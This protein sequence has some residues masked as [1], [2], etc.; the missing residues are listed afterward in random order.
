MSGRLGMEATR[1]AHAKLVQFYNHIA[2]V[3]SAH[4]WP[5]RGA[6]ARVA[7]AGQVLRLQ[8]MPSS[9]NAGVAARI[10]R[11]QGL[12][13]LHPNSS[14]GTR[15]AVGS[16]FVE[17]HFLRD[18]LF[19]VVTV[20]TGVLAS[21]GTDELREGWSVP[22]PGLEYRQALWDYATAMRDEFTNEAQTFGGNTE[23]FRQR[24]EHSVDAASMYSRFLEREFPQGRPQQEQQSSSQSGARRSR[25]GAASQ[26][27]AGGP[28]RTWSFSGPSANA[29]ADPSG[30]EQ[31]D[32]AGAS[33]AHPDA[34][35]P[36]P[37]QSQRGRA[38]TRDSGAGG[39][40]N[41]NSGHR[42]SS[43]SSSSSNSNS[44][45]SSSGGGGRHSSNSNSSSS[46]SSGDGHSGGSGNNSTGG[47][48]GSHSTRGSSSSN[49]NGGSGSRSGHGSGR[50]RGRGRGGSGRGSGLGRGRGSGSGRGRGRGRG[51]ARGA[52]SDRASA[53]RTMKPAVVPLLMQALLHLP[54]IRPT[55]SRSVALQREQFSIHSDA[56]WCALVGA[57]KT[58]VAQHE[59]SQEG[60]SAAAGI[61]RRL[62]A[63]MQGLRLKLWQQFSP[64]NRPTQPNGDGAHYTLDGNAANSATYLAFSLTEAEQVSFREA[65]QPNLN[66]ELIRLAVHNSG[67]ARSSGSS[68]ARRGMGAG[69]AGREGAPPGPVD[70]ATHM[71]RLHEHVRRFDPAMPRPVTDSSQVERLEGRACIDRYDVETCAV[72]QMPQI[73]H[74]PADRQ[75]RARWA[76]AWATVIGWVREAQSVGDAA[77]LDRSLKWYLIL[78]AVIFRRS[79]KG[80]SKGKHPI[81][82]RLILFLGGNYKGLLDWY[83]KDRERARACGSSDSQHSASNQVDVAL[84]KLKKGW[85]S[86][87]M[88]SLAST[89]GLA[90]MSNPEVLADLRSRFPKRKVT[91]TLPLPEEYGSFNKVS[92]N[93]REHFRTLDDGRAT[94]LTGMRNEYLSALSAR[95]EDPVANEAIPK[96]EW[97]GEQLL[98]GTLPPWFHLTIASVILVPLAKPGARDQA[99]PVSVGDAFRCAVWSAAVKQ[100]K[101][102][103]E[104]VCWPYQT[105]C[106]TKGAAA[107]QSV[108]VK[109]L[110]KQ[111]PDWAVITTD[112]KNCHSELPRARMADAL[113]TVPGARDLIPGVIADMSAAQRVYTRDETG[114][115]SPM[116]DRNGNE[117]RLEEG[118]QQGWPPSAALCGLLL[119]P[120]TKA[121]DEVLRSS[122]GMCR[123]YQDDHYALG[124]VQLAVQAV[125]VL[126]GKDDGESGLKGDLGLD[127][128]K[129]KNTGFSHDPD[130]RKV[131][132]ERHGVPLM[133]VR[134]DGSRVMVDSM[135]GSESVGTGVVTMGV[136]I[137]EEAF[138]QA[139]LRLK[140]Q[141]IVRKTNDTKTL[142]RCTHSQSL[143][144]LIYYCLQTLPD[145]WL[146]LLSPSVTKEFASTVDAALR[147]IQSCTLPRAALEHPL[148]LRRVV[149][150]ARL[151]GAGLRACADTGGVFPVK[152]YSG[153]VG[154]MMQALPRMLDLM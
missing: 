3:T 111:H 121:A 74:L 37:G 113:N 123:G 54:T 7:W 75:L 11:N 6:D 66:A 71:S 70:W 21:R 131:L 94:S 25:R 114:K 29:S 110:L 117:I 62:S 143:H 80:G 125:A 76:R 112:I 58:G 101:H 88:R 148:V 35:S 52:A 98:A 73:E 69:S 124:P 60:D 147:D 122:G 19:E 32:A 47:R 55:D 45:S 12:Q 39:N 139:R 152:V 44:S 87:A 49:S 126:E 135:D 43:N 81:T 89:S 95:H 24:R 154:A 96:A 100:F 149:A 144:S 18:M 42:D 103:I 146:Q 136:P 140:S 138:E 10:L 50:G 116:L 68:G 90:D 78:P 132:W 93:L 41:G 82:R 59:A 99:R 72:T 130:V 31:A 33:S 16:C 65:S 14:A 61:A 153:F 79:P 119:L 150:P 22:R 128:V 118:A 109:E 134:H 8:Q 141:Q 97:L 67:E 2:A 85:I 91:S 4:N 127:N 15:L 1:A 151:A 108:A 120:H 137:G 133:H 30:G 53:A 27:P 105:G 84:R 102:H 5:R 23:N 26:Q 51:R 40:S 104:E 106:G 28:R 13:L 86:R 115:L 64:A 48:S 57:C 9:F 83:M 129:H 92:L 107:L 142:L 34:S 38:R 20:V 56:D 36:R 77:A 17:T 145:Y 46:S 63:A